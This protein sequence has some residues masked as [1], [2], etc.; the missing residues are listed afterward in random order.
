M[1]SVGS[2]VGG[3]LSVV[4]NAFYAL[5]PPAWLLAALLALG[6]VF[7]FRAVAAREGHGILY[8]I[9]WGVFGFALGNLIAAW[10]GSPLP[11]FGD[12]HVLEASGG[13]WLFLTT[14]NLRA[15]T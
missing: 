8:F 13:A 9:P 2:V 12:V 3:A 11:M 4:V 14:A 6:N 15:R 10:L 5:V 7:L 1:E